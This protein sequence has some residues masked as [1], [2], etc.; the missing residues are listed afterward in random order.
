MCEDGQ[1]LQARRY[2]RTTQNN[3][4]MGK[5][6][7]PSGLLETVKE[8]KNQ[9]PNVESVKTRTLEGNGTCHEP[10]EILENVNCVRLSDNE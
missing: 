8:G 3:G 2:E 4:R 9:V 1:I 10:K 5:A 7:N 6:Q